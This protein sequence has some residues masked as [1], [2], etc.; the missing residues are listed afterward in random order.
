VKL[1]TKKM[2]TPTPQMIRRKLKTWKVQNIKRKNLLN[3]Q[4][5][6]PIPHLPSCEI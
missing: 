6:M 4:E 1:H 3:S 5:E 2:E